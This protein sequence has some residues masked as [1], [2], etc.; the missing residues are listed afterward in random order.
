MKKFKGVEKGLYYILIGYLL[1]VF[2]PILI[3]YISSIITGKEPSFSIRTEITPI[4]YAFSTII[5]V[6]ITAN[7]AKSTNELLN[8]QV[9]LRKLN[10]S[11]DILE[12]VYSPLNNA[13]N[14][15]R[16]NTES[17]LIDRIPNNYNRE[18][19]ALYDDILKINNKYNHLINQKINNRFRVVWN[20][21][22][23][24]LNDSTLANYNILNDYI[25]LFN[26]EITVHFNLE[27]NSF[28]NLQQL[29]ENMNFDE[30]QIES[31]EITK[32]FL[33][34]VKEEKISFLNEFADKNNLIYIQKLAELE[35]SKE[36]S[37]IGTRFALLF[38][39]I[40]LFFVSASELFEVLSD[41]ITVY[42]ILFSIF[43][44]ISARH[45][46]FF[47]WITHQQFPVPKINFL[48]DIILQ[49]ERKL[50]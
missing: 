12:N 45:W 9:R 18:F 41:F 7:Y 6:I 4:I 49:I 11:K 37:D 42:L 17:P 20:S 40:S 25:N 48:N 8:E 24:Y 10:Y 33:K 46:G 16:L 30:S 29:G 44:V 5:L 39:G 22:I 36:K 21:W 23:Q 26:A 35:I 2:V 47:M 38:T 13:L 31:K 19:E 28:N 43:L 32:I 14:K 50:P 27:K 1:I 34:A 3:D 15:Y